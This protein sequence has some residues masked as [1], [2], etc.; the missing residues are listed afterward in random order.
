MEWV[1]IKKAVDFSRETLASLGEMQSS[2]RREG[3][4]FTAVQYG[5]H[6]LGRT[7]L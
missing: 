2:H 6:T 4:L 5:P 7:Q 1:A 3:F